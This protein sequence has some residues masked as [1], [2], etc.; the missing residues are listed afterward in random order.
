MEG[1]TE[2]KHVL[3]VG[4]DFPTCRVAVLNGDEDREYLELPEGARFLEL[5]ELKARFVLIQLY[6]T[7]CNDCVAETKKLTRFFKLVEADPVLHGQLKIIGLGIYDSNQQV[8]RFRK[9]YD[10][11]YPLFSDK[12]GQIFECLG[13]A[14]LPLAYLVRAKG[15]G[16][17][18]IELI[19]R[20]YFEPDEQFLSVLRSAVVRAEGAD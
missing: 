19:K 6:N 3:A 12:S 17:W 7:L 10:V 8:V 9:H 15:D 5:S 20:G 4:D 1:K 11:A 14:E 16:T 13:Q 18:N 2:E